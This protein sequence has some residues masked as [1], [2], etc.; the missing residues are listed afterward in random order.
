[1]KTGV[2]AGLASPRW[3]TLLA[4]LPTAAFS[5]LS[6]WL[7][8][9]VARALGAA[10]PTALTAAFL[11]ATAAVPFAH[12]ATPYPRPISAALLLA[13]FLL[14][15]RRRVGMARPGGSRGS[16]SPPRSPCA[17]AKGSPWFPSP[18]SRSRGPRPSPRRRARRR[19]RGRG[20]RLRRR[21]RRAD[22]GRAV[23]EPE[24]V[25]RIPRS[26]PRDVHA[27]AA[28][29]G[30]SGMLLQWAGPVLV[31]LCV[32]GGARP[33]SAAAAA[34]R[35]GDGGA[36]VADPHQEPALHD[37]RERVSRRR[38]PRSAGSGSGTRG[39]PGAPRRPP[40]SSPPSR[41]A[42]SGRSISSG[43][44]PSPPS[45]RRS[46]S[47]AGTPRSAPSPWN[48]R[49]H[50]ASRCTSAAGCGSWTFRRGGRSIRRS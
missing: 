7:A 34:G 39:G 35:G 9:R 27:E 41:C 3:L 8:H 21:V 43:R 38:R 15:V 6:V 18:P 14:L 45:R 42:R 4:A 46:F 13:A 36:P 49:G 37:R 28:R 48:R 29:G 23:R 47:R 10:E 5:T 1:M 16:S 2:A 17:G 24:G 44:R 12:G 11:C 30:T 33:E 20:A 26:A 50:T 22:L 31:V 32:A 25:R 40:A 19:V